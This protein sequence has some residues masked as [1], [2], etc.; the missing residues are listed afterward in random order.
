MRR[1]VPGGL[2]MPPAAA[3]PGLLPPQFAEFV[4]ARNTWPRPR[5][6][7]SVCGEDLVLCVGKKLR[8]YA[9]HVRNAT[10]RVNCTGGGEG[11][12]HLWAKG[13]LAGYLSQGGE[14]QFFSRCNSC[15]AKTDLESVPVRPSKGETVEIEHRLPTGGIADIAVCAGDETM[16]VVEVFSTSRTKP[17][18]RPEEPWYEVRAND[19]LRMLESNQSSIEC[20]RGDRGMCPECE[21]K[22]ERRKAFGQLK[23]FSGRHKGKTFQEASSDIKYG[24]YLLGRLVQGQFRQMREHMSGY[25]DDTIA[26]ELPKRDRMNVSVVFR[27]GTLTD[28]SLL[29]FTE[30]LVTDPDLYAIEA[31]GSSKIDVDVE[32]PGSM[33]P[34]DWAY[35]PRSATVTA[36]RVGPYKA[37]T[38][39]ASGVTLARYSFQLGKWTNVTTY[40][41]WLSFKRGQKGLDT[42]DEKTEGSVS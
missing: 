3:N 10:G 27:D 2:R 21:S 33:A 41:N 32:D 20:V 34:W 15:K 17:P 24:N 35:V 16:V 25:W 28:R 7:C 6:P 8:P 23:L 36:K 1:G 9:R 5:K 12:L 18:A 14:L 19:V 26:F 39:R 37:G 22:G 13:D 30:Y 4:D 42:N 11:D 38:K 31:R 29:L 40:P